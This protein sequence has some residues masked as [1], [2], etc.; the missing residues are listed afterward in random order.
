MAAIVNQKS[1]MVKSWEN[2]TMSIETLTDFLMSKSIITPPWQRQFCWSI[3]N[4]QKLVQCILKNDP[5]PQ[6]LLRKESPLKY[7]LED[8]KQR[9]T[10]LRNYRDDKFAVGGKR[11]SEL[12][13]KEQKAILLYEMPVQTYSGYTREEAVQL[14]INRQQGVSLTLGEK[15]YAVDDFSSLVRVT[16]NLLMKA[17]C[18]LHNEAIAVWGSLCDNTSSDGELIV[19]DKNR[20]N[21]EKA[22]AIIAGLAWGSRWITKKPIDAF[23]EDKDGLSMFTRPINNEKETEE[24]AQERI[25]LNLVEILDIYRSVQ[26]KYK[27]KPAYLK[28]Q[29]D[30]GFATGFIIFGMALPLEKRPQDFKDKW[31]NFLVEERKNL[32]AFRANKDPTKN[33]KYIPILS[34]DS[35]VGSARTWSDARWKAG[36][37][38]LFPPLEPQVPTAPAENEERE[39]EEAE[40]DNEDE[41]NDS[42]DDEDSE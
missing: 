41:E 39:D 26:S 3:P 17:E 27:A 19:K 9:L 6:I 5:M 20:K 33:K 35:I 24:Q 36:H 11:F 21:L 13:A 28:Q 16:R 30:P 18:G 38:Y 12:S 25:R 31:V 7:S 2:E 37:N 22:C 34:Q 29:F 8:G 23:K 15:Y 32:A 10:T 14:F 40:E 1:K 42:E 4:Q